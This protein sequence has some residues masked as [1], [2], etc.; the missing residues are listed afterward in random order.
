MATLVALV[1]RSDRHII[2][3]MVYA[4]QSSNARVGAMKAALSQ[5]ISIGS[6]IDA[7]KVDDVF[8]R[9]EKMLR[10]RDKYAHARY[11]WFDA[12]AP[13]DKLWVIGQ[14]TKASHELPLHDLMH[15]LDRA[16][17]L[18]QDVQSLVDSELEH[19][20][21]P[22]ERHRLRGASSPQP[23]DDQSKDA[24]SS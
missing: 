9:A 5:L 11:G 6:Q 7:L 4:I 2:F 20:L 3:P 16:K 1:S 12:V 13:G 8:D 21:T 17:E 10:M 23:S 14:G 15:Q 19:Y 22:A 18:H 24:P